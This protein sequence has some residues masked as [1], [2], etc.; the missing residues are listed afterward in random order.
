MA[1]NEADSALI[2]A[3]RRLSEG[4]K[5][6]RALVKANTHKAPAAP[7]IEVESW[8]MDE[9]RYYDIPSPFPTLARGLFTTKL[10]G[11]MD[12]GDR[13][14]RIVARGYD[15]FFNI[16]EVPWT[17]VSPIS[18]PTYTTAPSIAPSPCALFTRFCLVELSAPGDQGTIYS[19]AQV[20]RLHYFHLIALPRQTPRMLQAFHW[21]QS[22]CRA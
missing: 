4:Q 20:E 7:E 19:H 15:K 18:F 5:K 6:R 22:E 3:L 9:F 1:F 21:S 10:D 8:K 2:N 12:N 14:Y 11:K 16:G 17:T 13:W